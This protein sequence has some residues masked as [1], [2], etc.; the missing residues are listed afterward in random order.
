MA[1]N[2]TF[3]DLYAVIRMYFATSFQGI[4]DMHIEIWGVPLL[5]WEPPEKCSFISAE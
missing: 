4:Y 5:G 3:T 1:S 2:L